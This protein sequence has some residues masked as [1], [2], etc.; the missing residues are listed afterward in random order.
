MREL[1]GG[2]RKKKNSIIVSSRARESIFQRNSTIH[3]AAMKL[4]ERGF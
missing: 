4:K 2:E 1:A 3:L